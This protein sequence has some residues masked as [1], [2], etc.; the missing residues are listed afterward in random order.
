MISPVWGTGRDTG[1]AGL[2]GAGLLDV[3]PEANNDTTARTVTVAKAT[4]RRMRSPRPG[5]RNDVAECG[6]HPCAVH[7]ILLRRG[8]G[9]RQAL[10]DGAT[11]RTLLHV[12]ST[13]RHGRGAVFTADRQTVYRLAINPAL[14][15]VSLEDALSCDASLL[16]GTRD[17]G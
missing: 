6:H 2:L 10:E 14:R 11:G 3:H 5:G 16:T 15:P 7:L 1:G 4:C 8:I 13:I 17:R 12:P 9:R